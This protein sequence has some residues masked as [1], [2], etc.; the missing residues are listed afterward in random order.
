RVK[1]WQ[2]NWDKIWENILLRGKIKQTMLEFAEKYNRMDILE[3]D[4]VIEANEMFY[5][6]MEKSLM[7]KGFLDNN[8]VYEKWLEWFKE[9]LK[10]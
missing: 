8:Y 1:E 6:L 10:R 3:A 5:S 7:E 2:G 9:G 4:R